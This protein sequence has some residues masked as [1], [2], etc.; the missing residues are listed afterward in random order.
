MAF[1]YPFDFAV[2]E[3]CERYIAKFRLFARLPA[4]ELIIGDDFDCLKSYWIFPQI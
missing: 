4:K 3:V 2:T 1:S